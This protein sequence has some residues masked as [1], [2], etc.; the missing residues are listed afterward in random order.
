M[1]GTKFLFEKRVITG[2]RVAVLDDSIVRGTTARRLVE[3]LRKQGAYQVLFFSAS[4]PV[5][6][7]CVYGIDMAVSSQ[8]AA[9]QRTPEQMAQDIGVEHLQYQTQPDMESCLPG[10]SLCTACFSGQYPTAVDAEE[11]AQI[12]QARAKVSV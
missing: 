4:P 6:F 10:L 1:V 9:S 2:K 11:L 8:L 3:S 12:G 7:P 5:R